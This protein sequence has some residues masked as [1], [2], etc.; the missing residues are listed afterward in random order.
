MRKLVSFLALL[1]IVAIGGCH[2]RGDDFTDTI[3]SGTWWAESYFE[4]GDDHTYLFT[5][6]VFTFL[7]DGTVTVNRPGTQP[8]TGY[9][10]EYNNGTRMEFNFG[11]ANPLGKL[12][13]TWAIDQF[14][15]DE[16]RFH[17]LSA[18][19]TVLWLRKI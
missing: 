5:G 12:T 11:S 17:Q 8:P 1:L 13:D 10:N 18:P 14:H 6:Y 9:W 2:H 16:I 15:D 3:T 4:K 19:A 7:G